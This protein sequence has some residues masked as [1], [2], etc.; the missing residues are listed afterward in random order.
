MK[1]TITYKTKIEQGKRFGQIT[2]IIIVDRNEK[3]TME[4]I[5]NLVS[6]D[7]GGNFDLESIKLTY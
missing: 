3:P 7:S 1:Y 2:K 5:Q 6:E 4:N